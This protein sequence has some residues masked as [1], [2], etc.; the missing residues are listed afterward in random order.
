[1][2]IRD[3]SL[4]MSVKGF[5]AHDG[6]DIDPILEKLFTQWQPLI[7]QAGVEA[8]T[9]MLW[10]GDGSEIL[11]YRGNIDDEFVWGYHIGNANPHGKIP[12]DPEGIDPHSRAYPYVADPVPMTYR[13]LG[14]I[15][16]RIKAIGGALC[17]GRP[18]R[19][20]AT[21]DPGPE[22]AKSPFKYERHPEIC[23]GNL[24][25][26]A[27]FV[28]C[29]STLHADTVRYAGF[30]NGITEGMPLGTFLGRQSHHFLNDLGYD[31]LWFSNGFGFGIETWSTI[32]PVFDGKKYHEDKRFRCRDL[33]LD[34][35]RRFRAECPGQEIRVRGTNLTTGIDLSTDGAPIREIYNSG[36]NCAPPP[37]S[38]WAALDGNFG[39]E[40]AGW[41]SHIAEL[42]GDDVLFR[43][44]LHDPWWKNSPW[45]DRY[46]R[47]AHDIWLPLAVAR[48]D[49]RGAVRSPTRISF[50]TVDDSFGEMPD[51]VPR[52]VT[53]I[54]VDALSHAPDAP[55]PTVWVYPFEEYHQYT[56][57]DKP[58]LDEPLAGDWLIAG[59]IN[60][61]MPINAVVS[62]TNYLASYAAKP[63]MYRDSVLVTPV[64]DADTA[65]SKAIMKH[66]S[67]GGKALLYGPTTR[68]GTAMMTLLGLAETT[69]MTGEM[70]LTCAF[71]PDREKPLSRINHRPEI[72]AGGI[73]N[74]V[75]ATTTHQRV[76][77]TVTPVAD[78][79]QQR[80][81]GVHRAD[82]AWNGGAVA[83]V[84]GTVSAGHSGGNLLTLDDQSLYARS[85]LLVRH[86]LAALGWE[87]GT[88]KR[89]SESSAAVEP[90]APMPK[91]APWDVVMVAQAAKQNSSV[92]GIHRYQNGLW[93]SGYVRDTTS[94]L[95][96][97]FPD[98]APLLV[99]CDAWYEDGRAEYSL[100]RA[101]HRECR[102]L[103]DQAQAGVISCVEGTCEHIGWTRRLWVRG[104]T[105]AT[106]TILPPPD[107]K[108]WLLG[109][110]PWPTVIGDAIQQ[111][112]RDDGSIVCSGV[113]GRVSITW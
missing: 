99:G 60:E 40:L 18:I 19:L 21:F 35:W 9:V 31:S 67:G 100:P 61:G 70:T 2:T 20:C 112:R 72:N 17:D 5:K 69:P 107:K 108:L 13:R 74:V 68:A 24:M 95:R 93:L 30:P 25:G 39:L 79:T 28:G 80:V 73:A 78:P 10:I 89:S 65:L 34:F 109:N 87:I 98:G 56:F 58:R 111:R 26:K 106:V 23:A 8:V 52:E 51:R 96:L 97:R 63:T 33:I 101:W 42:P 50:L 38:P 41:M 90:I 76:L 27:S 82:P 110:P 105:N 84:R 85:E 57:G 45:L 15:I 54:I 4:E 47:E 102:V 83:W 49:Q 46:G 11:D 62:T 94:R 22:F 16:K 12:N 104:L 6:S 71:C 77:S 3:L 14:H 103:V 59:A 37:N 36:F 29:Y 113:T 88:I 43:Y 66:I 32:G 81:S 44:Y 48:I 55:P 53:P 75:A 1:M 7:R 92:V 91:D 64:P 86:A